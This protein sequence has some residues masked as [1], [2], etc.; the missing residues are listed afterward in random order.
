MVGEPQAELAVQIGLAG[1]VGS[2]DGLCTIAELLDQGDDLVASHRFLPTRMALLEGVLLGVVL[3]EPV[4][5]RGRRGI[6]RSAGTR[7]GMR[8]GRS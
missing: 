3:V 4:I 8:Y 2:G 1:G 7:G 6:G 5:G